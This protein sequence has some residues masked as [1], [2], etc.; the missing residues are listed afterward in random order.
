MGSNLNVCALF[1]LAL[2][3]PAKTIEVLVTMS[4]E[5][6]AGIARALPSALKM[7]VYSAK[8]QNFEVLKYAIEGVDSLCNSAGFLRDFEDQEHLAMLDETARE[9][10]VLETQI[11]RYKKQLEKMEALIESG[12]MVRART[13]QGGCTHPSVADL[14]PCVEWRAGPVQDRQDDPGQRGQAPH[15]RDPARDLQEVRRE[16][17]R[18]L[19][20]Y[21]PSAAAP[22]A[23]AGC[24]CCCQIEVEADADED[25]VFQ[26]SEST[27]NLTCP[28]TQLQM[29][30]PLRKYV[31]WVVALVM[32][33][34]SSNGDNLCLLSPICGHTYSEQG[35]RSHLQR[36]K[37][38]PVAGSSRVLVC[39]S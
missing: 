3:F 32:L 6:E 25:V 29:E 39:L 11:S 5:L 37:T 33:S 35:I 19:T 9:F 23:H 12:K 31:L 20:L 38:C 28:V 7:G 27:R 18:T 10:A 8:K 36:S 26:E 2:R 15:E 22:S 16:G 17:R 30:N 1:A 24:P 14:A 4:A 34:R 13:G 21:V